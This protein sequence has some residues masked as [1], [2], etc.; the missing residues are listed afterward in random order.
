MAS[1]ATTRFCPKCG[2]GDPANGRFCR[3]CGNQ[4]EG[5]VQSTQPSAR[6]KADPLKP[7]KIGLLI[8]LGFSL[9]FAPMIVSAVLALAWVITLVVPQGDKIK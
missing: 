6:T 2:S 3:D 7:V 1:P 9:F 5:D 4:L 8:A